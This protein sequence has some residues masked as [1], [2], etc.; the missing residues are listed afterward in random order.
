M[1]FEQEIL[2][3]IGRAVTYGGGG[4]VVAFL[5]FRFLGSKWIESKFAESLEAYKHAQAKELEAVKFQN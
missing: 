5:L 1:E 4:A 2:K 3:F